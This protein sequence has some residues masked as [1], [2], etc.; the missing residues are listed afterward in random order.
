MKSASSSVPAVSVPSVSSVSFKAFASLTSAIALS[1]S[2]LFPSSA[3]C[4]QKSAPQWLS[5]GWRSSNYPQSAWFTGFSQDGVKSGVSVASVI[6]RVE[7][8]ARSKLSENIVTDIVSSSRNELSSVRTVSGARTKEVVQR[9]Y[10]QIILVSTS[11][12]VAK[13]ELYSYHDAEANRVYAFAAVNRSALATYYANLIESGLADAERSIDLAKQSADL[14]RKKDAVSRL[15]EGK[16][17]AEGVFRYSYLLIAVDSE[18]GLERSQGERAN[19]ILKRIAAAEVEAESIMPVFVTGKEMVLS[20]PS[21]IIIPGLQ[22]L[23][24]DSGCQIAESRAEAGYVITIDARTLNSKFDNYFYHSESTVK[25]TLTN[26]KTGKSEITKTI[27]GPKEGGTDAREAGEEAF[28]AVVP[29][30]W[31]VVKEKILAN[32]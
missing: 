24:S 28:R 27:T 22:S 4:Q 26:A 19:A 3:L 30:I 6:Q 25:I 11:A 12:E 14:G 21:D 23:L 16:K 10:G 29:E 2:L 15:A 31:K 1:L 7:K 13:T 17:Q 32:R 5:D 9:D 18:R 20:A 8:D